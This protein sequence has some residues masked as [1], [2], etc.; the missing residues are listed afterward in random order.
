[1]TRV[2]NPTVGCH[3]LQLPLQP[4]RGLLPVLLLGKQTHNGVNS[5]PKTVTRQRQGCNLNPGP[6]APESSMLTTRLPSH[7]NNKST[8][9][10]KPFNGPLSRITWVSQYQQNSHSLTHCLCGY[11]TEPLIDFLHFMQ[12][13]E[14]AQHSCRA[15]QCFSAISSKVL[16]G[17]E[18]LTPG[19]SSEKDDQSLYRPIRP[20]VSTTS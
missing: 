11:Y 20:T 5:L 10:N 15:R 6:S 1:M 16:F 3:Y 7:P 9:K 8:T 18:V 14:F 12:S 13:T 2:I 17:P 4:L 19:K